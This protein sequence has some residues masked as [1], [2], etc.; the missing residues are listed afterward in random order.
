M[1]APIAPGV[2]RLLARDGGDSADPSASDVFAEASPLLAGL[3]AA[4][5]QGLV[6]LGGTPGAR[7]RRVG[8][9]SVVPH[10]PA[11]GACHARWEGFDLHAG[12]R[13]PA[14]QRDRRG[15]VCRYALR[16]PV[17]EDDKH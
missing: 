5:V 4:S 16:P 14:E 9:T 8:Q 17:A 1:L 6:A 3:A 13:V 2:Q 10:M 12:L 11:P 15:R 7:P